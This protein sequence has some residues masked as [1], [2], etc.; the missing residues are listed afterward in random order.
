MASRLLTQLAA[1]IA[2]A[3]DPVQAA[4]LRAQRGIYLARQGKVHEAE[5]IVRALREEFGSRPNA[6]VTAWISLVEA[7][8]HFYSQPGPQ[9]LDRLKRAHALSRAMNHPLLV[10][11]CAAWL[12]HIEFNAN[13]MEPMLQYAVEALR[14]AQPDHHATL[15]RVSLVIAD[16]FH[17]AGR[18]DLAKDWYAA[19][20]E[21]A[22]ADGD[23]AMISAMLHNVAAFRASKT[24][25][26]DAFG[27]VD[28][29]EASR[30]M[31][32]AE[33]T[34]NFDIGIGTASLSWFV[35]LLRAQLLTVDGRYQEAIEL[36][37]ENLASA[38]SQGVARL[39]IS[40]LSDNAWCKFKLGMTDAALEDVRLCLAVADKDCDPDDLAASFARVAS[41]LEFHGKTAEA[42]EL[43][44][45]SRRSFET[46]RSV[47]EALL[48]MLSK[49]F[50]NG[51]WNAEKMS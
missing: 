25:L 2:A 17:Y 15:A 39:L 45:K 30:A 29:S 26:G 36:F 16:A 28:T 32:E 47:Q 37:A 6:E 34:N 50:P 24:R 4:C 49:A 12:A 18:F 11:L 40:F 13:R 19:V 8:N 31:L 46:H 33:S 9:A 1:R 42:A 21:H 35:P 48:D 44:K 27:E 51:K 5:A 20:R 41:I 23:D 14:L 3:R 10:P 38:E 43:R 22:L 7:L